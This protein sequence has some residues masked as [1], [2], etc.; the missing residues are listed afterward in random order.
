[1][2]S[3]EFAKLECGQGAARRATVWQNFQTCATRRR[4]HGPTCSRER[5]EHAPSSP[6][7]ARRA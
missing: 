1:M 7:S 5:R 2:R 4:R 6:V 3:Y